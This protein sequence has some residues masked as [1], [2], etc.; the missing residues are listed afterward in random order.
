FMIY[1]ENEDFGDHRSAM[2][3][4]AHD[5]ARGRS[6]EV[7]RGSARGWLHISDAVRAIEA[8]AH[9]EEYAVINIG[10]PDVTPI[11]DLAEG[12]RARLDAAPSLITL[13]DLP[14]RMTAAKQPSLARMRDLLGVTPKVSLDEGL[15]RVTARVRARLAQGSLEPSA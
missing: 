3:R 8:A 9:V 7:H 13:N 2:I 14:A 5:L 12:L 11:Q 15:D 4:F 10:H 6:I 1:D